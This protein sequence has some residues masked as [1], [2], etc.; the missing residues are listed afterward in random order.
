MRGETVTVHVPAVIGRDAYGAPV[1]S[2]TD[3]TVS[4]VPV[5]PVTGD[6]DDARAVSTVRMSAVLPASLSPADD[7]QVTARGVRMRM[8]QPPQRWD[9][10]FTGRRWGSQAYLE[11]IE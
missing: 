10:P 5:W 1:F 3:T 11:V 2:W 4:G 7:W 8:S 9:G 6:V